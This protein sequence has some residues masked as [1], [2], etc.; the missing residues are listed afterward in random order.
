[1]HGGDAPLIFIWQ[2]FRADLSGRHHRLPWIQEK[3]ENGGRCRSPVAGN[4][5]ARA[6][7][8]VPPFI[9]HSFCTVAIHLMQYSS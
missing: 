9:A 6:R 3:S 7:L 4:N 2:D 1:M 5:S 8:V